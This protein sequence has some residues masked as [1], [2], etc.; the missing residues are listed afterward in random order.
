M[1]ITNEI[2][3][4]LGEHEKKNAQNKFDKLTSDTSK[5]KRDV[6][7]TTSPPRLLCEGAGA[8]AATAAAVASSCCSASKRRRKGRGARL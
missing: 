5:P 2:D 3:L 8:E 4:I 6:S 1:G 7:F